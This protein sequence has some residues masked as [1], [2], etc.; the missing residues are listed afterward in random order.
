MKTKIWWFAVLAA[1]ALVA[2]A[3][4]STDDTTTTTAATAATTTTAAAE[5]T[6]TPAPGPAEPIIIGAA[7]DLTGNMSFFDGPAI[8]A[9]QIKVDEINAAGGVDGRPIE[10]RVIDTELDPDQTQA[11]AI[12]LIE[13]GA[14]VLL[15]TCDVDFA[16][17]AITEGINAGILTVASC[18]GTDQMGP[19]RFGDAGRL[20]FSLGNVAQDEGA[21]MAEF[22][23]DKGHTKAALVTDNLLVYFQDVVEAFKVRWLELGGEIV[24]EESFTS[25]DGT[26][27]NVVTAIDGAD[28]D[29]IA[30]SS[31]FADL[32]ATFTTSLRALGNDTTIICSWACDGSGWVPEGLDNFYYVTFASAFGDDPDPLVNE[33]AEGVAVAAGFTGTGGFVTGASAIEAIVAAIEQT[34]GTV[35]S[36]LAAA[37]EGFDGLPTISGAISFS[38]DQHTVFGRAYRVITI[39]DGMNTFNSLWEATSPA[40]IR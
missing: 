39:V 40:E 29:I 34:G 13:G 3:C 10:L 31:A 19:N 7:M 32:P 15:V 11:A 27:E 16:T 5:T 21:A 23:F 38:E 8:A 26:I 30:V 18:I 36:E 6:T 14:Q 12:D 17:P 1:F 20:A 33:L 25:F 22:A 35:G 28:A 24:A 9:A 37:F 2:A 4:S